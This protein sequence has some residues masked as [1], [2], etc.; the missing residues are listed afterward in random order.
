MRSHIGLDDFPDDVRRDFPSDVRA[1]M[2]RRG[3]AGAALRMY[4]RRGWNPSAVQYAY[5][6][7][8]QDLERALDAWE[9]DESN[10]ALF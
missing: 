1:A 8:S 5:E 10:P 7:A 4:K 6:R 2:L 9:F 3:R